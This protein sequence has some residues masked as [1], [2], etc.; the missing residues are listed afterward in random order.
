MTIATITRYTHHT[1]VEH[2]ARVHGYAAGWDNANYVEAYGEDECY[3]GPEVPDRFRHQENVWLEA[4][5]E[6]EDE[7]AATVEDEFMYGHDWTG[8]G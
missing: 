7:F 8:R 3:E 6:G 1:D 2:E 4:F 5:Q